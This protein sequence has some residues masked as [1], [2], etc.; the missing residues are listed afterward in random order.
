MTAAEVTAIATAGVAVVTSIIT[1]VKLV[2]HLVSELHST[3]P[4]DVVK[5]VETAVETA[6]KR[7]P[8]NT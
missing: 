4:V 3:K 8:P 5:T 1:F 6:I 2:D 7:I